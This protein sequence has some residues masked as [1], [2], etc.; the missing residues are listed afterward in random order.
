MPDEQKQALFTELRE[1]NADNKR[2]IL[3]LLGAAF[4]IA[5]SL[6]GYI[7]QDFNARL[8]KNEAWSVEA[9]VQL[10]AIKKDQ[11]SNKSQ[12]ERLDRLCQSFNDSYNALMIQITTLR[13]DAATTKEAARNISDRLEVLS[14]YLRENSTINPKNSVLDYSNPVDRGRSN[15]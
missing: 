15:D 12:L 4:V 5:L 9:R 6:A 11:E 8:G 14:K 7:G 1:L 10:E 3:K 2:S 13:A